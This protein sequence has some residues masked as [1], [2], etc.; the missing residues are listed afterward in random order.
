MRARLRPKA[1]FA[2]REARLG[3]PVRGEKEGGPWGKHGFPHAA[4]R[5]WAGG[6][7]SAVRVVQGF[8]VSGWG[9]ADSGWRASSTVT[10]SR[11]PSE[12]TTVSF[13]LSPG[14]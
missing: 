9:V 4:R 11:L 2:G 8:V 5:A 10:V 6:P 7:A 1:G 3:R 12:W 14:S 13:T